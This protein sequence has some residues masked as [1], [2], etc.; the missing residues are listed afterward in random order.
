MKTK[1]IKTFFLL[2]LA[3]L[4]F[5]SGCTH[6]GDLRF[7]EPEEGEF[8]TISGTIALDEIVEKD[9]LASRRPDLSTIDN[10]SSFV[11]TAGNVETNANRD[12]SFTLLNVPFANDLVI[13]AQ[14]GKIKLLKRLYPNDLYYRDLSSINISIQTTAH[15]LI[16]KNGKKEDKNLTTADINAREYVEIIQDLETA[17]RLALQ[18]PPESV[19][20]NILEIQAVEKPARDAAKIILAR[21]EQ[22]REANSVL[23]HIFLRNDIELLKAYI[24]SN[25][26]NDFD[27]NSSWN[28]VITYFEDLLDRKIIIELNWRII[29]ME[30][31][32]DQRARVRTNFEI[33]LEDIGS[34]IDRF[35]D[36][37]TFD[38]LWR[39]E[40]NF[41][42][43]YRNFPYREKHPSTPSADARW[44]LIAKAHQQLY[45]ALFVK[46]MEMLEKL[47]SESFSND[48][49][50]SSSKED[51]ILTAQ[52]R[53]AI[54]DIKS[55]DYS[56][57]E[58]DFY[59]EDAARIHCTARIV[60]LNRII[61][62]D[63]DSG[64]IEAITHWKREDGQWRLLR[65]MPYRFSHRRAID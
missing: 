52:Q 27:S 53:F 5:F 39:L 7:N 64:K 12:G 62:L 26:S 65:N 35:S 38:A 17:I 40:G 50:S 14:S 61:G 30:F 19:K 9:L 2:L 44:G 16:W 47:I 33:T 45:N 3:T 18:L 13:S 48:F 10:F 1:K 21:E 56:V 43:L 25:F 22:L 49:D 42:K 20:E 58:I 6:K 15:A 37:K 36:S 31:L 34:G 60:V 59:A 23:K 4:S 8:F 28:D 41:W 11:V 24:S 57:N 63:I 32:P 55:A 29:D 46:D 51:I 54:M